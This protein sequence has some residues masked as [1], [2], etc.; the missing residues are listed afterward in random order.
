MKTLITGGTVVNAT[1]RG[2]ADVLID[3]DQT[4]TNQ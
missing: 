2:A 3:G 1:G 4:R